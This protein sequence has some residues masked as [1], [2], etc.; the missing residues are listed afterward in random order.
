MDSSLCIAI[1]GDL[2]ICVKWLQALYSNLHFCGG[3]I[4]QTCF[5]VK[6]GG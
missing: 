3:Q 5:T 1:N 2:C 6:I 4:G